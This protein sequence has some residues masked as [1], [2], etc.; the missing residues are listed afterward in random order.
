LWAD[1]FG[2]TRRVFSRLDSNSSDQ[3]LHAGRIRAKR[4][5]YAAELAA[6]ELGRPGERFVAAAK[7]LQD[8]LGEHQDAFVAEEQVTAWA[9]ENESAASAVELLLE[10]ERDR[11]TNARAEWPAAWKKLKRLGRRALP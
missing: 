10:R 9:K 7:S 4:A 1:E 5:R 2:R 3:E 11:R 6:H 8:V